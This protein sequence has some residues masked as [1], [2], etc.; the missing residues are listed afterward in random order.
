MKKTEMN[1]WR[2]IRHYKFNS[3]LLRN[4]LLIMTLIIVP[5]VGI[6][7]FVYA[8]N[9]ANMR[10][11]IENSA[12]SELARIRESMDLILSDAEQLSVRLKVDPDVVILMTRKLSAPLSYNDA[13]RILR[14]QQ[15]LQ[16]I[17]LTNSYL[18]SIFIYSELNDFLLTAGFS[19]TQTDDYYAHWG[20]LGFMRDRPHYWAADS[21]PNSGKP[22]LSFINRLNERAP[23]TG[24]DGRI[25]INMN[26]NSLGDLLGGNE[27]QN[28]YMLD[29]RGQMM[30]SGDATKLN[31]TLEESNPE[32]ASQ[33]GSIPASRIVKVNG[34]NQVLSKLPSG[35]IRDWS[36]VSAVSLERYHPERSR[37]IHLMAILLLVSIGTAIIL[38]FIIALRSYRPIREILSLI[39]N[40][41]NP[42]HILG[43]S[44]QPDW[45][46]SRYILTNLS[47]SF[48][49]S[50]SIEAQLQEKYELLRKAQAIALQAQI[51]P[52]FLYNTLDSINWKVMRLTSGKNEAS[53][54]IRSLSLLLRLAL[55]TKEDFVPIGKELEH[56]KLYVELQKL[57]YKEQISFECVVE[58]RLLECRIVKLMLQPLVENAIYH[59]VKQSGH[60]GMINVRIYSSRDVIIIRVRDNGVGIPPLVL[61][62]LNDSLRRDHLQE[63]EHIGLRNVNQRIRL[64]FGEKYG[65]T[66]RSKLNAGTIVEMRLPI[67]HTD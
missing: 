60:K 42:F 43:K 10:A 65:L 5:L 35:V 1:Y 11:E 30:Y 44:D 6:S 61:Q 13:Q 24:D 46:E 12:H 23:G 31:R 15:I 34:L 66:V 45:N 51:N 54:M 62:A 7:V 26:L 56:V 20:T 25:A 16:T 14:I 38:A 17:K 9:D 39:E 29:D 18:D 22:L 53:Q 41:G 58:E 40:K 47:E 33:L 2:Y 32:L 19:T 28:V 55:E 21:A 63:N 52:H 67:L 37:V 27:Q 50:H 4:F 48:D 8:H 36:Y 57:R 49:Q 3:I 59:G 64:A